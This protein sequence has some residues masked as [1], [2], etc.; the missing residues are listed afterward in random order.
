M[1]R[2]PGRRRPSLDKA[3]GLLERPDRLGAQA[4]RR[5]VIER[6]SRPPT[7]ELSVHKALIALSRGDRGVRLITTNFDDRFVET[8]EQIPIVDVAPKL[9]VPTPHNWASLVH[10]HGRIV[11]GSDGSDLVLTAADFGRA[12]LTER[13]ASRFVTELFREFTVV[14]VGYGIGD[15][16]IS[17]MVDALAAERAKGARFAGAYAF[18]SHDGTE[19]GERRARDGWRAKNVRPILY[20]NRAKHTLLSDTLVEWAR[21]R[22]DPFHVRSRI[23]V[24]EILNLPAGADDPVVERVTWALQDPVAAKAL[25][26]EPPV[27][28]EDDYP[29]IGKWIELFG[30][31]GLLSCAGKEASPGAEGQGSA[32]VRLVTN[33]VQIRNPGTLDRTRAHLARWLA[34]HLH[35]PQVLGWVLRNGGHLHPGLRR[36]VQAWLAASDSSI[37]PRLRTCWTILAHQEPPDRWRFLWT[38]NH[39]QAADSE[40]ERR[41][42][43][44]EAI[45]S[46]SPHLIVQLG[47]VSWW[48]LQASSG[49][50]HD[51]LQDLCHLKLV[52]GDPDSWSQIKSIIRDRAV[53]ARH[54]GTLTGYLKEALVLVDDDDTSHPNSSLY[55]PSIAP[56]GQN[57][58]DHD[59]TVL[60]DLARDSYL[61]LND[62]DRAGADNLLRNW[63]HSKKPLFRRLALHALT[64][65]KKSDIQLAR[66][67]LLGGR[68]PGLWELE[69]RREVLRFLRR[70]GER[71]PRRLRIEIVRAI[72]AG[73]KA[74]QRKVLGDDARVIRRGQALLL[75]KLAASGAQLNKMSKLLA[76]EAVPD[77]D[78]DL[79]ERDEFTFW[80][81]KARWIGDQEFVPRHLLRGSIA[82][83]VAATKA[84]DIA[85]E[86]FRAF[87]LS[88]PVKA[89]SALRRL[90]HGR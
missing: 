88:Q 14:F 3:L 71:L 64:E 43:E 25:A 8:E 80:H 89:V 40:L 48:V 54:A 24:K 82:D 76:S 58:D 35:V 16:V 87:A 79:D 27:K 31:N 55:R 30:E 62:V 83:V 11:P 75:H 29:K 85:R 19:S 68:R 50:K 59:W 1:S 74:G 42:I 63:A 33:G 23:A 81:G 41:Q 15:P 34:R 69:L 56:H 4:V 38:S 22:R 6:L 26:D 49:K 73:P 21:I 52:A 53:L 17:Y 60:I 36:E 77:V 39:H 51:P 61:A 86:D 9:P 37:P 28:D 72:H 13:W 67:L 18:A 5:T 12:Y 84:S 78:G 70:A 32:G 47:P 66:K 65:N 45:K 20:D 90:A 57:W 46:L 44:D 10:L 7:G 2:D